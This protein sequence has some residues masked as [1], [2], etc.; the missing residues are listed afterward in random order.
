LILHLGPR[1]LDAPSCE[2]DPTAAGD[3]AKIIQQH[4]GPATESEDGLA[5]SFDDLPTPPE[6]QPMLPE[7]RPPR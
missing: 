4:E 6:L 3:M 2:D 5:G 1:A 7:R